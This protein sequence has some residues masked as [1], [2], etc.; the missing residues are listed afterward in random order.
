[1]DFEKGR[2]VNINKNS[3]RKIESIVK[4]SV[5]CYDKHNNN[6][7]QNDPNNTKNTTDNV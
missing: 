3:S 2:N 7:T 1:M 5:D 4:F 6:K